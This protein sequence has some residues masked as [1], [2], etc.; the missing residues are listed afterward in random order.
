M[1]HDV[2]AA[3]ASTLGLDDGALHAA[4][5]YRQAGGSSAADA[6]EGS[7]A[8]AL[9]LAAKVCE[10]PRRSRDVVNA[11]HLARHGE[12]LRDS[13][14]YWVLKEGLVTAEQRLLRGLAFDTHVDQPQ[15][16]M[17]NVLRGFRAPRAL[18]EL[19]VA[20]LNDAGASPRLAGRPGRLL[21]AASI[22]LGAD[23][24]HEPLPEEWWLV[25]E[26]GEG[27][28]AEACH[29]MLDAYAAGAA[30]AEPAGAAEECARDSE[31]T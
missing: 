20:L 4:H 29:A 31:P 19:A 7:A 28:V 2:V 11:V 26:V 21:A 15:A 14:A 5:C 27:A 18:F 16:L 10:Q 12:P 3:A 6:D 24:L 9:F 25:L 13:R 22:G 30:R 17:L 23:L 8:A 1:T